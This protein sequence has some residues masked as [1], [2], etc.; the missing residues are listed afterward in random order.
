MKGKLM[1]NERKQTDHER[2]MTGTFKQ[3]HE[4]R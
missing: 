4:K 1:E 3:K 2:K